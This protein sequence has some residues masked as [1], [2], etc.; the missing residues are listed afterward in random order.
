MAKA[1]ASR[2][3]PS[4]AGRFAHPFFEPPVAPQLAPPPA[5][6]GLIAWNKEKNLGPLPPVRN[7]GL[8][9]LTDIIGAAAVLPP[10]PKEEEEGQPWP[11]RRRHL[12]GCRASRRR[13][14]PN[15]GHVGRRPRI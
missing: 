13:R 11:S 9:N 3:T 12:V 15:G 1:G 5:P 14:R 4:A 8:I 7:N 2:S 6:T 10:S